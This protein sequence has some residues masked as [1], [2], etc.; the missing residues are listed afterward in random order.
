M[1]NAAAWR[2]ICLQG[3]DIK[4]IAKILAT[5]LKNALEYVIHKD[6]VGFRAGKYIGET[7][8]FIMD[9]MGKAEKDKI[10]GF[11]LSLD[12]EKA[13]DS[14][15]WPYLDEVL[16]KFG[17]GMKFRKWVRVLR[18]NKLENTK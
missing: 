9:L 6:K 2:P 18:G 17:F 8:Q 3:V 16:E 15:E 13:F 10:D 14:V 11:I 5:R 12:I 4:I 1:L 7:L